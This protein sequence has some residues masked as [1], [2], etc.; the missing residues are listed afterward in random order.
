MNEII[1]YVRDTVD[2]IL[3]ARQYDRTSPVVKYLVVPMYWTVLMIFAGVGYLYGW[4][5]ESIELFRK[6]NKE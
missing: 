4:A 6:G 1:K 2:V 5:S 3:V